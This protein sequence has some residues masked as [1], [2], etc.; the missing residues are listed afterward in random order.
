MELLKSM[1]AKQLPIGVDLR[2]IDTKTYFTVRARSGHV[3][4]PIAR[5]QLLNPNS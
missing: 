3:L 4:G 1:P 2:H 5:Y